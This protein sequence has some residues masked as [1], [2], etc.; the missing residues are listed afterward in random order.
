MPGI[1]LAEWFINTYRFSYSGANS[2]KI[3][4]LKDRQS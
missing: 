4:Q 2:Y 3:I 1:F